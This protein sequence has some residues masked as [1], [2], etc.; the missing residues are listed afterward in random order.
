MTTA[1]I[2]KMSTA[3]RIQA[4]EALWDSL[5]HDKSEIETPEWHGSILE[6]R[7]K[8]IKDG[9]AEFLTIEELKAAKK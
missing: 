4:M 2:Q 6:G 1:E 8:K 3:E 7:M 9:T 5:T